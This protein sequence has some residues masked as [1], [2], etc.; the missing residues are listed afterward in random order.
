MFSEQCSSDADPR[1]IALH[2]NAPESHIGSGMDCRGMFLL[3][4]QTKINKNLIRYMLMK[5]EFNYMKLVAP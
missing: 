5:R 1:L 2:G 3:L 4:T